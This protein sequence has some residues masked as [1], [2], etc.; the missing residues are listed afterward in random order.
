[1]FL[2]EK[3]FAFIDSQNIYRG[4]KS[5]GWDLDWN[6][7]RIYLKE[8]YKVKKAYI[9]IGYINEKKNLYEMLEKAGFVLKFKPVLLDKS[10]NPKGNIDADLVLKAIL[11]YNDYDKAVIVSSDGDF[12]SLVDYLYSNKK[13]KIVLSPHV[14]TCSF[15]LRKTAKDKIVYM[16]N[17]KNKIGI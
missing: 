6:K 15:L 1:M 16:N 14:K 7:F 11:K 10:G 17:L 3:N 4:I 2:K 12:Y 9:F 13:L 5:L 8:K